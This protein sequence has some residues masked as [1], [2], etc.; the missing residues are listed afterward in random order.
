MTDLPLGAGQTFT[1]NITGNAAESEVGAFV[2]TWS[3]T[4]E[5]AYLPYTIRLRFREGPPR[6]LLEYESEDFG[7]LRPDHGTHSHA[8]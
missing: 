2:R 4:T 5:S 6:L 7:L 8:C 1:V 3:F